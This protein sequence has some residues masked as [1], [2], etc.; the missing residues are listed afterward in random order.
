MKLIILTLHDEPLC[1]ED[2]IKK[3]KQGQSDGCSPVLL[4]VKSK[5]KRL[6]TPCVPKIHISPCVS[7]LHH[8]SYFLNFP[9][10]PQLS[11][12][13]SYD[14][15]K[16]AFC[17]CTVKR[18]RRWGVPLVVKINGSSQSV[19]R[20]GG[21]EEEMWSSGCLQQLQT[22]RVDPCF[23]TVY[24][25]FQK[26]KN[27]CA[28]KAFPKGTENTTTQ[29]KNRCYGNRCGAWLWL[30]LS[31]VCTCPSPS[32]PP[33]LHRVLVHLGDVC[34]RDGARVVR[35]GLRGRFQHGG[36]LFLGLLP[37][38]PLLLLLLLV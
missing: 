23:L 30:L 36:A 7:N 33:A 26:N 6:K 34:H 2:F 17:S 12:K 1:V 16:W 5:L 8:P 19:L 37:F 21:L 25:C 22:L 15:T 20:L 18:R 24:W 9:A 27:T 32:A 38:L 13:L 31:C 10:V 14:H 35:F 11:N 3:N 4:S 29:A 28:Q